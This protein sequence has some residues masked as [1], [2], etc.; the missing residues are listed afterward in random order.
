VG[1]AS[2]PHWLSLG[3]PLMNLFTFPSHI[4]VVD[5]MQVLGMSKYESMVLNEQAIDR[6]RK[7]GRHVAETMNKPISEVNWMGDEEGTCPVCHS[8]LLTVSKKNPVECPICGISGKIQVNGDEIS[9]I[10][11]EEEKNRSRLTLAGKLEHWI[12]LKESFKIRQQGVQ[13]IGKEEISKRLKK[14]KGYRELQVT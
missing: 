2:T 6:A 13:E 11:D 14:Y 4:T 5:Q 9:V 3:L 12:E 1:G 10:F 8:D 7:L